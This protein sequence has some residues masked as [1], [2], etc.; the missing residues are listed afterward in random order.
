MF[1]Q[2]YM[3]DPR[4]WPT[5]RSKE[6][7]HNYHSTLRKCQMSADFLDEFFAENEFWKNLACRN[8]ANII[9]KNSAGDVFICFTINFLYQHIAGDTSPEPCLEFQFWAMSHEERAIRR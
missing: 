8:Q 9:L 6:S 4:R 2:P 1:Q 7:V 3:L 5:G